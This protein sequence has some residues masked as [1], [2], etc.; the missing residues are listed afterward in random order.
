MSRDDVS[1]AFELLSQPATAAEGLR[2]LE[3]QVGR[4]PDSARALFDLGSAYDALDRESEADA[5]Y[6]RVR[7]IGLERLPMDEQPRWFVQAGSTLRLLGRLDESRKVLS[8]GIGRYPDYIALRAFAA[9][10]ELA[11]GQPDAAALSLLD[12]LLR[13][14]NPSLRYYGRALRAYR[15]EIVGRG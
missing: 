13:F 1:R 12:A 6:Q 15:D 8:E 2:L 9:L 4:E 5:L 10:T 7:A 14:D 3:D 11:D